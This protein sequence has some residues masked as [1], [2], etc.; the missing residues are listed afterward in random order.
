M[1]INVLLT[2][3]FAAVAIVFASVVEWIFHKYVLHRPTIPFLRF[4]FTSH[5]LVHHKQF[6]HDHTYHLTKDEYRF[7][8]GFAWWHGIIL[9]A[10]GLIPFGAVALAIGKPWLTI[11]P[12]P[13]FYAYVM[14][15]EFLH[16]IMHVPANR[17]I[18]RRQF[19]RY[20]KEHHR[21]HHHR[22]GKNLNVVLPL[23]DLLLGTAYYPKKPA[24]VL[25][26]EDGACTFGTAE[27]ASK[28]VAPLPPVGY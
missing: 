1:M 5:A 7:N 11:V 26:D 28:V 2:L 4:A 27:E 14:L 3:A 13:F 8:V 15:F 16:T 21:L 18:E 24:V 10:L 19:F 23:A 22:Y 6:R 17:W 9:V 25:G 20:L 12:V